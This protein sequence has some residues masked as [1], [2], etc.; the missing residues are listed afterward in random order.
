MNAAGAW[1]VFSCATHV[2]AVCR[3]SNRSKVSR[4]IA[5]RVWSI[6]QQAHTFRSSLYPLSR[7]SNFA[8]RRPTTGLGHKADS[9]QQVQGACIPHG[10]IGCAS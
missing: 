1:R 2:Q 7:V 3:S 9:W 8:D 10:S 5:G 4:G 6:V